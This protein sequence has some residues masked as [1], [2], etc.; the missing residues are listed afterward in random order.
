MNLIL[1]LLMGFETTSTALSHCLYILSKY[2][3]EMEKLQ[4]EI[5]NNF[6]ADSNVYYYFFY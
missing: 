4:S 2:P 5:D 6:S 3:H 1:F